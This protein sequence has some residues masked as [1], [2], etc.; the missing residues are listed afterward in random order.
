[1][2]PFT[3]PTSR[4]VYI[5]HIL[6]QRK[7][8]AILASNSNSSYNFKINFWKIC[9]PFR[10][11]L[12]VQCIIFE[13]KFLMKYFAIYSDGIPCMACIMLT[14]YCLLFTHMD[15]VLF[16]GFENEPAIFN[17]SCCQRSN[18]WPLEFREIQHK[19][20]NDLGK[21]CHSAQG[22]RWFSKE[23]GFFLEKNFYTPK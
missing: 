10:T 4:I 23:D 18:K 21:K 1:M 9:D 12:I 20:L 3:K 8:A 2:F 14:V 11:A 13:N 6:D 19:E 7:I 5:C 16:S 22:R 17:L 15:R